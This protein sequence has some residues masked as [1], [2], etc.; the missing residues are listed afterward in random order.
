LCGAKGSRLRQTFFCL[1][2]E[3]DAVASLPSRRSVVDAANACDA[4]RFLKSACFPHRIE[5]R[6][7]ATTVVA[8]A[9][10]RATRQSAAGSRPAPQKK[11]ARR[12]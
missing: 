3:R 6:W 10:R 7:T 8:G 2:I 5:K 11:N 4:I 1:R 12:C 9:R